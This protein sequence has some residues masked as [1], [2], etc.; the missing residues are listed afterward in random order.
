MCEFLLQRKNIFAKQ[1]L[2]N[3]VSN[4]NIISGKTV[5]Y[6]CILLC[7]QYFICGCFKFVFLGFYDI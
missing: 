7:V 2:Y 1:Y 6:L 4:N 3:I 5:T